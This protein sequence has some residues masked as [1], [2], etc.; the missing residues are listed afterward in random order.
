MPSRFRSAFGGT[1]W[2]KQPR[3]ANMVEVSTVQQLVDELAASAAAEQLC[4]V[5]FYATWC[6]GCKA[7]APKMAELAAQRPEIKF[8]LIEGEEN[9]V[10]AG[11][12]G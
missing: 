7:L 3:P 11:R 6:T 2:W 1:P 9:K 12:H 10:G 5:E 4:V 8:L